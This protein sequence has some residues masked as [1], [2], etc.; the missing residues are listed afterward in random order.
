MLTENKQKQ[1]NELFWHISVYYIYDLKITALFETFLQQIWYI[2][3]CFIYVFIS[4]HLCYLNIS[5]QFAKNWCE[6]DTDIIYFNKIVSLLMFAIHRWNLPQASRHDSVN[7]S[8]C[9]TSKT[10]QTQWIL[11]LDSASLIYDFDIL[12]MP[13]CI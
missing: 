7:L 1:K 12:L 8:T 10:K 13:F 4:Q 9:D 3:I 6:F 11:F 5:I 2:K